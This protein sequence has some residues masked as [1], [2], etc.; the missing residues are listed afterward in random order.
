MPLYESGTV[1]TDECWQEERNQYVNNYS[2]I[3]PHCLFV[4]NAVKLS[5]DHVIQ[6][7][8]SNVIPFPVVNSVVSDVFNIILLL[9]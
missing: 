8:C 1:Q 4:N 5:Q 2:S 3:N 9:F 7:F 6:P